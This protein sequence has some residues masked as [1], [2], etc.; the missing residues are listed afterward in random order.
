M[1]GLRGNVRKRKRKKKKKVKGKENFKSIIA[2]ATLNN[3]TQDEK[4]NFP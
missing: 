2:Y 1:F 3:K 4:Y